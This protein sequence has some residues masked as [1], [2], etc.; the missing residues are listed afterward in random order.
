MPAI[1]GSRRSASSAAWRFRLRSEIMG[2]GPIYAIP[3][4]LKRHNLEISDIGL[5]EI[6]ERSPARSSIAATSW[7]FQRDTERQWRRYLDRPSIGMTGSRMTAISC[8]KAGAGASNTASSRCASPAAWVR[9]AVRDRLNGGRAN[10]ATVIIVA[11]NEDQDDRGN[12]WISTII[13]RR[14]TCLSG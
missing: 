9:R 3:K 13:R 7:H 8:S 12:G 10:A 14:R 6:N 1:A 5:W 2:I 4:L 11:A